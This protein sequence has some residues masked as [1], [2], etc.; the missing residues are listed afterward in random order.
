M[1]V[2]DRL[3]EEKM[4]LTA[5]MLEAL[6]ALVFSHGKTL[7][8]KMNQ[9]IYRDAYGN[10]VFDKF[11][12]ER[13]YFIKA[14]L[15]KEISPEKWSFFFP[16]TDATAIFHDALNAYALSDQHDG[17]QMI[18][19]TE[20]TTPLDYELICAELLRIVGWN[21]K[22]TKGSGDQGIDVIAE[23]A[24]KKLVLQCKL[25]SKPVGNYAV[26]EIIAGLHF[27]KAQFAAVVTN[28]G[29]TPSA[30]A[31][32]ASSNVHLLHH[33]DLPRFHEK[34]G[35]T[36]LVAAVQASPPNVWSPP[37]LS[38][39]TSRP[40]NE[41]IQQAELLLEELRL[42]DLDEKRK[43]FLV[44]GGDELYHQAVAVVLKNQRASISLVQRHFRIGYA[45]AARLLE[46][47]EAN[48]LISAMQSN[49]NRDV[50]VQTSGASNPSPQR[51]LHENASN[52]SP[53]PLNAQDQVN[54]WLT[55]F[56]GLAVV[57]ALAYMAFR[58]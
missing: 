11:F 28:G 43:A 25:Y 39:L 21:A 32:A 19:V 15:T 37:G 18:E 14:V 58:R 46:V 24:G 34:L 33:S 3:N 8:L 44:D 53:M 23:H 50:L 54:R 7:M 17:R 57:V 48:E 51:D 27:E 52:D 9:T 30:R 35:V 38:K 45:R 20:N 6:R 26:Q 2:T 36:T 22:V 49:G 47:M 40:V 12:V 1:G 41:I 42:A 29:Y 56:A 55:I 4:Q 13:D 31:L 5:E 10:D 16:E